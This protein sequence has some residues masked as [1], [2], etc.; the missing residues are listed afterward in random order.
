MYQQS[1]VPPVPGSF[2]HETLVECFDALM[3]P[4]D[5]DGGREDHIKALDDCIVNTELPDSLRPLIEQTLVQ[6]RKGPV[7]VLDEGA[8]KPSQELA[9]QLAAWMN[10]ANLP[11][12]V[13]HGTTF[14][15]LDGIEKE[16]LIPGAKPVW[17]EEFAPREHCDGAV[18]FE[19]TWRGA[20]GWAT[21]AHKVAEG[22]HEDKQRIPA[23]IRTP[24][25]D[26]PLEP[27][28]EASSPYSVMVRSSV[29]LQEASVFVGER[30]GYPAWRPLSEVVA[31]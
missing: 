18:F 5:W 13:Y 14:G 4:F 23:V 8:C 10:K 22:Y 6:F 19:L 2:L 7:H 27:D 15:C 1:E 26:L 28:P 30:P 20:W 29:T 11:R 12:F 31:E 17:K 3:H 21:I 25:A 16:G 24:M 9:I